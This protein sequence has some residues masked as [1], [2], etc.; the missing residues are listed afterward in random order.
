MG[1]GGRQYKAH[2]LSL[3][4]KLGRP[5]ASGMQARHSCHFKPCVNQDH[6]SEGTY[7][8]NRKDTLESYPELREQM[9]QAIT[10]YNSSPEGKEHARQLGKIYGGGP[11]S[12]ER[13]KQLGKVYGNS[14]ENLARLAQLNKSPEA[15]E[16]ARQLGEQY[17]NSPE[18][19]ER[20]RQYNKSRRNKPPEDEST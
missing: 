16:R 6:L 13:M 17:G 3:E 7:K 18:N 12:K 9:K 2:R 1:K 20:L 8:D 11:E 4:L 14:P 5:I 19:I 10:R 15:R